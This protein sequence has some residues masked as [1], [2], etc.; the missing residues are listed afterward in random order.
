VKKKKKGNIFLEGI[1]KIIKKHGV[2]FD[3]ESKSIILPE[4]KSLDDVNKCS[5]WEYTK[6][7]NLQRQINIYN[8]AN[9]PSGNKI[10]MR[11]SF[12]V[13]SIDKIISFFEPDDTR[14]FLYKL[15]DCYIEEF[16][17]ELK[18]TVRRSVTLET[19]SK[20]RKRF[21][22]DEKP[23][24]NKKIAPD[25]FVSDL[26]S[27]CFSVILQSP[28]FPSQKQRQSSLPLLT[29]EEQFLEETGSL[30][31]FFKKNQ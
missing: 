17:N 8:G 31:S 14:L 6:K 13:D 9:I 29:I 23:C 28:F 20:K 27:N 18:K 30:P 1:L 22:T 21:T 3:F 4:F 12:P 16:E 24:P 5:D 15:K 19:R 10:S 25:S 7:A 2:E 26:S 11:F